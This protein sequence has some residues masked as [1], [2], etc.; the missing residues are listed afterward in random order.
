MKVVSFKICPFVQRITALLEAKKIPYQIEFI[1]LRDKPQWFLDIS[2]HGQVPVL[3][4]D[5]GAAI[6]E[7]DAI[8][9]YLEEAYPPLRPGVPPEEKA[10]HR[11]WSYLATKHYLVQCGAQ[12]SPDADTLKER[13]GKLGAAFDRMEARLG[14]APFFGGGDIGMVDIAWLT[15]LHRADIIKKRAGYDFVGARPKLKKWQ[16]NLMR[17]GLA[18]KSVAA[19]FEE[20]FAAFYLS[21]ETFLGRGFAEKENR[22]CNEKRAENACC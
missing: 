12:R 9:E 1:S 3:V 22:C 19:D 6:F 14:D 18:E 13:G 4:A 15:L 7:S 2:P 8:A 20:T 5:N 10:A 11:A 17:T 21:D 16:R